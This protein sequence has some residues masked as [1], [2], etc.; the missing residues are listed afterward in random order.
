MNGGVW[1]GERIISEAWVEAS[2][3]EHVSLQQDVGY[4]YQWWLNTYRWERQ[5][6]DAFLAA[7]WGGQYII[8]FPSLEMVVV[9]TGGNYVGEVPVEE[10]LVEYI[11]PAVN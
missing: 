9:F 4:G 8:V 10:I 3:Q 2:T 7:G 5:S 6:A 11:L 1:Q